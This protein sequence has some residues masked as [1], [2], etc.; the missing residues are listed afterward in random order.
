MSLLVSHVAA[1][2][3]YQAVPPDAHT[4]LQDN[5]TFLMSWWCTGFSLVII[6]V[7][8]AGRYIRTERFF[9]EDKVMMV[10]I[11]PLFIR[12]AFVH[13]VL[14]WGTNNVKTDGLTGLDIAH[15][16]V[17]SRLVLLSRIFYAV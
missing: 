2:G 16:E 3:I 1:R 8:S 10:S 12:M 15:R 11:V 7:R 6:L 4:R 5:P 13:V 17:G 9:T 14:L